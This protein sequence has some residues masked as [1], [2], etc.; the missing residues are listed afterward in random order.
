MAYSHASFRFMKIEGLRSVLS[1]CMSLAGFGQMISLV[2]LTER[3]NL[4]YRKA[5]LEYNSFCLV[6][7]YRA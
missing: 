4:L 3:K 1:I 7:C 5:F 2:I 6:R